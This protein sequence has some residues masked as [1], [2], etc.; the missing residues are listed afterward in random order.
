MHRVSLDGL[1]QLHGLKCVK[2]EGVRVYDT[3]IWKVLAL[4]TQLTGKSPHGAGAVDH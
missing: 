4:M 1:Q 2:L 3:G